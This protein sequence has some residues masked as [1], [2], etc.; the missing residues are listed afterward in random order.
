MRSAAALPCAMSRHARTPSVTPRACVTGK[1][2]CRALACRER[3]MGPASS[4]AHGARQVAMAW[5]LAGVAC[6]P[7]AAA[8][9]LG[10]LAACRGARRERPELA[11][12]KAGGNAPQHAHLQAGAEDGARDGGGGEL[13]VEQ[14]DEQ[15]VD[16]EVDA[17]VDARGRHHECGDVADDAEERVDEQEEGGRGGGGVAREPVNTAALDVNGRVRDGHV[18]RVAARE[19]ERERA[20]RVCAQLG[21]ELELR[22]N[23][24][25]DE[26]QVEERVDERTEE[27]SAEQLRQHLGLEQDV[28][29][30]GAEVARVPE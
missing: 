6:R 22:G 5:Q 2:S 3:S 21:A 7:T 16:E 20:R 10:L 25:L 15:V 30:H 19:A 12:D 23:E 29:A 26:H 27:D 11:A 8:Q 28:E 4:R 17:D 9:S 13:A 18:V 24:R 1:P 14:R